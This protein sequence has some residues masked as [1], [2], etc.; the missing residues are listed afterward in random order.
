[1]GRVCRMR[2]R[3]TRRA[4]APAGRLRDV[5]TDV[6]VLGGGFAGLVAARDCGKRV[7]GC[8]CSR[9]GTASAGAR[10]SGR[11]PEPTS[12]P[13]TAARGSRAR[14]TR[15]S[16]R[17]SPAIGSPS[18]HR[19]RSARRC[20]YETER[21]ESARGCSASSGRDSIARRRSPMPSPRWATRF[22][23]VI[24]AASCRWTFRSILA[25]RE[26]SRPRGRGLLA[27]VRRRDGRGRRWGAI[28]V[29]ARLGCGRVRL[30][31][32]RRIRRDRRELHRWNAQPGGRDRLGNRRS[33]RCRD[34]MGPARR[35]DR[36][37]RLARRRRGPRGRGRRGSAAERLGGHR[38]RSA[39]CGSQTAGGLGA[40]RRGNDETARPCGGC[41]RQRRRRGLGYASSD[42]S[43]HEGGGFGTALR[44]VQRRAA[45]RSD[46]VGRRRTPSPHSIP[47]PE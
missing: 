43:D 26:R 45:V 12:R 23:A 32:R 44:R 47:M 9:R 39:A 35:R 19:R 40:T 4:A 6:V 10:G 29:A 22:P 18:R 2:R 20:G 21:A 3:V 16:V 34:R 17:R 1:M 38:V 7:G 24:R 41:R 37:R 33:F 28:D 15:T 8:S 11:C 14:G 46:D 27:L 5:D 42:R 25:R 30:H 31:D 36:H 13:S